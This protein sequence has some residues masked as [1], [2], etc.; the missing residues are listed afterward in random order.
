MRIQGQFGIAIEL[1]EGVGT[2]DSLISISRTSWHPDLST[3][4]TATVTERTQ[5]QL[6]E[7]PAVALPM[8]R[9][10]A[11]AS[12]TNGGRKMGS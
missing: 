12:E 5:P 4:G 9:L 6:S 10:R 8:N 1:Q 7:R 2:G 11:L 3:R